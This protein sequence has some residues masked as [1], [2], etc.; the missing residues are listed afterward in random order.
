MVTP[1]QAQK[2]DRNQQAESKKALLSPFSDL[3][4]KL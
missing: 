2:K 3:K 1:S 4:N